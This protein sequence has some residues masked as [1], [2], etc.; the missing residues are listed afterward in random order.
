MSVEVF[1]ITHNIYDTTVSPDLSFNETANIRGIIINCI[2]ILFRYDLRKRFS[3][4]ALLIPGT[5]C[6]IQ[7]LMLLLLYVKHS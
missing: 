4:H 5:A 1:K 7:L 2:I 6:L 3:L